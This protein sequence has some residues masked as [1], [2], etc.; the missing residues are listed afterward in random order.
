MKT[1]K[2]FLPFLID[3]KTYWCYKVRV[4]KKE[5]SMY[6]GYQEKL[7]SNEWGINNGFTHLVDQL[8]ELLPAQGKCEKPR[9]ANK[10]LEKFR[11]AQNAVYDLFNNGLGNRRGLFVNIFGWAPTQRSTWDASRMV[12]AHWEDRVEEDFTPIILAAAKEQ[13][14]V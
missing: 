8:N 13:G 10:N 2:T 12:W 1:K 14:L 4:T 3:T 6:T 11:R 5:T 9:T 7:F